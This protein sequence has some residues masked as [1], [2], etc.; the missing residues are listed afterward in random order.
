MNTGNT[1]TALVGG[2]WPDVARQWA[3]VGPPLRPSAADIAF[4]G[5]A[6][7]RSACSANVLRV[8]ILGVTPELYRL[9]REHRAKVLAADH[10]MAMIKAVWPGP[11]AAVV[12]AEWPELPLQSASIDLVVCDGGL[13][14][15]A[16]PHH[17]EELVRKLHRVISPGGR[18]AFRLFIPPHMKEAKKDVLEELLAGKIANLNILK[19][20]LCMALQNEPATGVELAKVWEAIH[21]VAPDFPELA[22]RVG[23]SLDHLLAIN[24]YKNCGKRYHFLS[25]NDVSDMFCRSPGGFEVETID[26]PT[27]ELGDRCPTIV[28]RRN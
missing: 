17:Q 16:H 9:A 8:L 1:K 22:A 20:R 7:A 6:V 5:A 3:Q 11:P 2:H 19:M 10:T 25:T 27:Y 12:C 13:H 21:D 18:C 28:F 23:W 4:F 15:L 26:T 14:L 24:T